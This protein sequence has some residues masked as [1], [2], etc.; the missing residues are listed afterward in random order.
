[1]REAMHAVFLYHAIRA[2][3]DM[4]ILNAAASVT[5]E[6]I[7]PALRNLLEDVILARRKEA[8]DELAAYAMKESETVTIADARSGRDTSLPVEQRLKE[9]IIKGRA[10]HLAEDLDEAFMKL[11]SA[12][13]IIEGRSWLA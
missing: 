2:G 6:D 10:E 12:V 3:L 11:G 13:K 9:S 4:G 7:D 5:Y 8:A 1:M